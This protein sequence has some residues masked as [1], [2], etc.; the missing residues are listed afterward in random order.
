MD[1]DKERSLIDEFLN[2]NERSF[3][4]LISNYQKNIYWH[5]RRMMGN[6][7]DADEIT[8]QVIIV[9]YKKLDTFRFQSSLKTW[10]YKITQTRCLNLLK[11]KKLKSFFNID[12]ADNFI[13]NNNNDIITNFED[14]EKLERLNTILKELP[15][16]QREVF[17]FRHYD[18]LS[19]EE[20]SQITGKSIG[21][22]KANYFHASKKIFGMM[23]NE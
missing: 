8:Q 12:E 2:G 23:E 18:E 5:A 1:Q 3:N 22:L 16:K 17:I 7:F 6:H 9:L 21:G 19:Y 10:I 4:E 14:K 15:I 11:K 20:I 13:K